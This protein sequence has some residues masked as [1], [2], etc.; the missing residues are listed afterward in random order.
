MNFTNV[1]II[2]ME[3]YGKSEFGGLI[4]GEMNNDKYVV[5][6]FNFLLHFCS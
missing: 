6:I 1:T 4:G 3:R 5:G 2:F